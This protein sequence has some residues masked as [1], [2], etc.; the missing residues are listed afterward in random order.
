MTMAKWPW[1]RTLG[2]DQG[3]KKVLDEANGSFQLRV[4]ARS[5]RRLEAG[6]GTHT[7]GGAP[8]RW[9]MLN[10]CHYGNHGIF[11]S[12]GSMCFFLNQLN[13]LGVHHL[14]VMTE[15]ASSHHFGESI[16]RFCE[17]ISMLL[18]NWINDMS[19]WF[20]KVNIFI[21]IFPRK[22]PFLDDWI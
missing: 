13:Q 11:R 20:C 17:N 21:H 15:R 14:V 10:Q 12:T 3:I 19:I 4:Q 1:R 16:E 7:S 2:Q 5:A 18:V 6:L 8:V 9:V 22:W